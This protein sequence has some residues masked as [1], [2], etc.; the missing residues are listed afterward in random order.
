[1]K[2][3][4][5]AAQALGWIDEKTR[6]VSP[7]IHPSSTF[8][9]DPDNQYRSGRVYARSDNPTYDQ[10]EAVLASLEN[11]EG[12]ALF[13]SGMAA[14]TA[15]FLSLKPGDHVVAPKMMYWLLRSWLL[16][17]ATEW[18]LQV[19]LVDMT[20]LSAVK[21]AMRP[22]ATKLIWV[23]TPA[24]PTWDITDLGAV[25]QIARDAGARL[26]VDSTVATPVFTRPLDLGADIVMHSATK[27][28]NGHSDLIGGALATR[29]DDEHWAANQDAAYPTRRRARGV[30]GLAAAARH[31][32]AVSARA[33]GGCFG[34][35]HRRT[36]QPACSCQRG[37]LSG[38]Q[39]FCRT[40][41]RRAADVGRL[42]RHA[43]DPRQRRRGCGDR[44]RGPCPHLEARDVD[45]RRR[46]PDRA[47]RIGRGVQTRLARAIFC[48]CPWAS[49]RSPT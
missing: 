7:L 3:A 12:A 5:V 21:A 48:A 15:V 20:D 22:G 36:F 14:A 23:E 10:A 33:D 19:D 29:Q 43:V 16:N 32:H 11:A 38:P 45:R 17:F 30:R 35:G 2:P 27:Y 37:A 4:T 18:G 41:E 25:S 31:A 39:E 26:A 9:R 47:S 8:I 40:R 44:H 49:R 6:S 42:R 46:K 28:L 34:T 13:A 1:M 24:N